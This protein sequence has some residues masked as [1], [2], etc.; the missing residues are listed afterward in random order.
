MA[1][2]VDKMV[3]GKAGRERKVFIARW[4][5]DGKTREK[6][7]SKQKEAKDY[8]RD[9]EARHEQAGQ[10]SVASGPAKKASFEE[11]ATLYT[12]ALEA[13]YDGRDPLE[14]QTLRTYRSYIAWHAQPQFAPYGDCRA[15]TAGDMEELR[16]T[17]T[18]KLVGGEKLSPRTIREVLRLSKAVLA[19]GVKHGYLEAVP[20]ALVTLP[21]TRREKAANKAKKD[22]GVFTPAQVEALLQA[23]DSLAADKNRQIART[24]QLYRPLA[25]FLVWTGA[26]ISEARGFPRSG[27]DKAAGLIKI[28]QRAAEAGEIGVTKSAEGRRD[29]PLHPDLVAPLEAAMRLHK[30]DLVFASSEGTPRSYH[31]LY[32]RMLKPLVKRANALAAANKEGGVSVPMLG[33]HAIRHAYAARLIAAGANLKQLQ[34]WMG[35][36]DPAFTLKEYG[37]LF[38]D[39]GSA[40][41]VMARMALPSQRGK[42]MAK[43][44]R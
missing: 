18:K 1:Y 17:L 31:N 14:A 32:N 15:I 23:A 42:S 4:K 7:F 22:E 21:P 39:D 37:H 8:A 38:D 44:E 28:R 36:H 27:F 35:H 3:P 2:V 26:R 24:W 43:G 20:G 5:Q 29:I 10:S 30:H 34:V 25:Y 13:G 19:F 6:S 11:L 41:A 12:A 16:E 9:M 40:A 33:F